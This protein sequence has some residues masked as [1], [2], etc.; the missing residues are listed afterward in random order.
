MLVA[1]PQLPYT[2]LPVMGA[3][4]EKEARVRTSLET[5]RT[6]THRKPVEDTVIREAVVLGDQLESESAGI[7]KS[8]RAH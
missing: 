2:S 3:G 4:L 6:R 8:R 7:A 1:S 5:A